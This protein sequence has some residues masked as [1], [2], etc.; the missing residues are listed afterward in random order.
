MRKKRYVDNNVRVKVLPLEGWMKIMNHEYLNPPKLEEEEPRF[1]RDGYYLH[2][3]VCWFECNGK[4]Y[5]YIEDEFR[6]TLMM[7]EAKR[8]SLKEK[9]ALKYIKEMNLITKKQKD[10]LY[11][12]TVLESQRRTANYF[13]KRRKQLGLQ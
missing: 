6:D 1:N 10:M 9:C 2:F 8:L 13:R 3:D 4:A 7:Y 5:L 12:S 11:R